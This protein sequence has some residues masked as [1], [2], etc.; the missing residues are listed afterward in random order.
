MRTIPTAITA[1]ACALVATACA[2]APAV[3]AASPGTAPTPAVRASTAAPAPGASLLSAQ[4]QFRDKG[5]EP[6]GRASLDETP[7][8]VLI[9]AQFDRL[10]PGILAIH[11]HEKGRCEP[12]FEAAGAHVNPGFRE[13]GFDN[14]RGAH[15]GDLPNLHV[16]AS[17]QLT[18]EMLAP[19]VTLQTG[20]PTSLLDED[21]SALIVH[22]K[23]DDYRSNPSGE[24][25]GRLACAV[26][27]G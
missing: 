13:H 21:G 24:A 11:I 1:A 7:P 6:V 22:E 5:G 15:A 8:G 16:P 27:T 3:P 14:P 9:K 12:D 17:G 4:A 18:V 2:R 19:G 23:A 20:R 25:G 10:P 26:I